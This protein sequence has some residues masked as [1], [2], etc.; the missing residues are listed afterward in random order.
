MAN[1]NTA[2]LSIEGSLPAGEK[3][4]FSLWLLGVGG[5]TVPGT[6]SGALTMLTNIMALS[7]WQPLITACLAYASLNT[8]YQTARVYCYPTGGRVAAATAS[9]SITGGAGAA[10]QGLLPNQVCR[11]VTL[12]TDKPGRSYRGRVYVPATAS[13]GFAQGLFTVDGTP[14][15]Q[16]FADFAAQLQLGTVLPG[17]GTVEVVVASSRVGASTFVNAFSTDNR[18]DVQRRRANKMTGITR[19]A[20]PIPVA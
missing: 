15:V 9:K 18:P 16:A 13:T 14:L 12:N 1:A 7:K 10:T 8:N 17:S 6:N 11:V 20:V 2:R 3:F 4:A 5:G 19:V